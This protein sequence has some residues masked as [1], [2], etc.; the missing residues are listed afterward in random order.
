MSDEY[1]EVETVSWNSR[2]GNSCMGLI[3]GIILFFGSFFVLY[4][5]EGRVDF[6]QVAKTAVEISATSPNSSAI[7]QLVSTS[8]VITSDELV[9]DNL[10]LNPGKYIAV[11]RNVEM[12]AWR[13]E[14]HTETRKSM[15]GGSETKITTYKYNKTWAENP[16]KSSAFKYSQT[17]YNPGKAIPNFTNRVL[18]AKVGVYS[19]DMSSIELPTP[20]QVKLNHQNTKLINNI[21]L[22]EDYLYKGNGTLQNPQIGD[23][24]IQYYVLPIGTNVTV[25]G[26]LGSNNRITAYIHKNKDQLYRLFSGSK[27]EAI[28]T[29]KTEHT[30]FT[31][32]MR[33]V[34]FMMMW[35]G[36]IFGLEPIS[37]VLDFLP[38]LG[39]ITRG[40]N[41]GSAFLFALV[42]SIVTILI[43]QLLHNV[44]ALG[45]AIAVAVIATIFIRKFKN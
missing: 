36:L 15:L 39:S 29:L 24:R 17:H 31:W 11:Q 45:L 9:G 43:S 23:L 10:F 8:G 25:F 1:T 34:G 12:Y 38:L 18:H 33:L 3:L 13:E 26:M 19:L 6:S 21:A 7:G 42:M 30:I 35:I 5:N 41:V 2:I 20:D 16:E 37:V 28:S 44:I 40:L 22:G 4:W 14:K 32:I 27:Q